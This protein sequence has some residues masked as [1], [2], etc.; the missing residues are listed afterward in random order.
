MHRHLQWIGHRWEVAAWAQLQHRWRAHVQ[1]PAQV[2][3]QA[4]ALTPAQLQAHAQVPVQP[5]KTK[6]TADP[7]K[8]SRWQS[9]GHHQQGVI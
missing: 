3:T 1:A 9:D 2:P 4:T 6:A 8:Y 5:L 7:E